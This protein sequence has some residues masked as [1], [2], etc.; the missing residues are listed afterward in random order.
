MG[1]QRDEEKAE[2]DPRTLL[3]FRELPPIVN[4]R[5]DGFRTLKSPPR[6]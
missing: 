5:V 4:R 1:A 2:S 6:L 3:G